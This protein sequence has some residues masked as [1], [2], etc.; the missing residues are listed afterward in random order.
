MSA[1]DDHTLKV[2]NLST[3]EEEAC[4]DTQ[5]DWIRLLVAF[6]DAPRVASISDD[7]TIKIWN[8]TIGTVDRVLRGHSAEISCLAMI[9]GG[10]GLV[11]VR[12]TARCA[13]GAQTTRAQRKS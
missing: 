10:G 9:P 4:I 2:W 13:S 6:A 1:S 8:L 11:S 12:M 5:L 3:G 7:R